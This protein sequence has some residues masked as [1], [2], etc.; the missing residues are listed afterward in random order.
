MKKKTEGYN[1]SWG[2][3]SPADKAKGEALVAESTEHAKQFSELR[4]KAMLTAARSVTKSQEGRATTYHL[5]T[6]EGA[7]GAF[8]VTPEPT[9]SH[10]VK[11]LLKR[12]FNE[13]A[14]KDGEQVRRIN[15]VWVDGPRNQGL[16]KALYLAAH[17]DGGWLY[18]SQAEPGAVNALKALAKEGLIEVYWDRSPL[19]NDVGGAHAS[20][21]TQKGLTTF[22]GSQQAVAPPK[23]GLL[24]K[25]KGLLGLNAFCPTGKGGG[26]DPSCSP[27]GIPLPAPPMFTSSNQANVSANMKAVGEL[28]KL[29]HSG[30]LQALIAHPGT[31][32]P[33]VQQHKAALVKLV[34]KHLDEQKAKDLKGVTSPPRS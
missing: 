31:S 33:K 9:A 29:A 27:G 8:K 21:I 15:D 20:R 5:E 34:T 12:K 23:K 13:S 24:G 18:N 14:F 22:Q 16:G 1:L 30:D 6:P 11:T 10:A 17:A 19:W 28:R 3:A 2:N 7:K 25:L 4:E 32:S 26:V